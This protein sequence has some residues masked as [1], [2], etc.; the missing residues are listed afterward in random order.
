MIK[1]LYQHRGLSSWPVAVTV[2]NIS[3]S[4]TRSR[5]CHGSD[6]IGCD[7]VRFGLFNGIL[8]NSEYIAFSVE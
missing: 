2:I 5:G 8:S 4:I 7:T 1:S 6:L 3:P